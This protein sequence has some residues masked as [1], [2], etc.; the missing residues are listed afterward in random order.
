MTERFVVLGLGPVRSEWFR[1]IAR[2]AHD[3]SIGAQFVKCVSSAD[4]IAHLR[5]ERS[6]SAAILDASLP[7][8]DRDTIDVVSSAG[9]AVLIV[10]DHRRDDWLRL[11]ATAVVASTLSRDELAEVLTRHARP[12][13]DHVDLPGEVPLVPTPGGADLTVVC[14]PGGTGASTVAMALGQAH[15]DDPSL[16]GM[17]LVIDA[18]RRAELAMLHD[19]GDVVPGI[20][21]AVELHRGARPR[22]DEVRQLTFSVRAR[23]YDLLL[24]LRR[25]HHWAAIRP[26][27]VDALFE[28]LLR[29]WRA[30]VVDTDGDAEPAQLG[31]SEDVEH[32]NH[33]MRAAL[34]HARRVLV[35][36][37]PSTKGVY[38]LGQLLN[39]LVEA[40]VDPSLLIPVVNDA[41]RSPVQRAAIARALF[42]LGP[43]Q[44]LAVAAPL[45]VPHHRRLEASV[46]DGGRLPASVVDAV[47][48]ARSLP[49]APRAE[50]QV[51]PERVRPGSLGLGEI[52]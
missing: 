6:Y 15:G 18:A 12:V 41:P 9:V 14:G 45:Y 22:L 35:V 38:S 37:H 26:R 34:Q 2:W 47:A 39:E 24:G 7:G 21:E 4:L 11:G 13:G 42:A 27:A 19:A 40:G 20:Q 29:G 48:G 3:G 32:R 44:P 43:D 46:R 51:E 16:G 49:A 5:S 31:G 36:G 23:R 25:P 8:V 52:A 1:R 33:L 10:D 30:V 28:S 50:P 17:V